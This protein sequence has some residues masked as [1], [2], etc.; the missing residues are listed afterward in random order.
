MPY[1]IGADEVGTGCWAGPVYICAVAAP[2]GWTLKGLRDSKRLTKRAR[3]SL[4][5]RIRKAPSVYAFLL[6]VCVEDIDEHG[7]RSVTEA[8]FELV[9]RHLRHRMENLEREVSDVVVDGNMDIPGA[10]SLVK[11]ED[12]IPA[13]AAASVVA[14]VLRDNLMGTM[15]TKHPGYGS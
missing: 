14:K 12:Q 3:E 4:V 7:V 11:A 9:V 2:E 6:G 10:R 13:V 5:E 8:G 1:V 15:G